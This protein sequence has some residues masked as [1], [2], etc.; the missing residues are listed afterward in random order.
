MSVKKE[1]SEIVDYIIRIK[2]MT[3]SALA[4][5]LREYADYGM[6]DIAND[7]ICIVANLE[8]VRCKLDHAVVKGNIYDRT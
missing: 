5:Y 4:E 8:V 3:D 6:D 2:E 1:T 7:L